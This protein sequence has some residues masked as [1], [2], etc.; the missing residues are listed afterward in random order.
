VRLTPF[1]SLRD[2]QYDDEFAA[3]LVAGGVAPRREE[4]WGTAGS[5]LL[6]HATN[7]QGEDPTIM[8]PCVYEGTDEDAWCLLLRISPDAIDLSDGG[9]VSILIRYDD[10]AAGRYDRLATDISMG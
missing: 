6:G 3:A 7:V 10:L 8:G 9:D 2:A 4:E 5:Q 1:L